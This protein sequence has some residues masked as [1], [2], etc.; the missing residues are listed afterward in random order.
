MFAY[1][2]QTNRI[3]GDPPD[4]TAY[5]RDVGTLDAYYEASMDLRAI[6]PPRSI[7]TTGSGRCGRA[8]TPIRP[9]S[10]PSTTRAGG[11]RRSTRWS[12]AAASCPAAWSRLGAG[13]RRAGPHRRGGRGFGRSSTMRYRPPGQDPPRHP[14]QERAHSERT[15]IGYDLEEDAEALPR[16][17]ERHRGGRRPPL[18]RAARQHHCLRV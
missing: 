15:P 8:A 10:S 5:W 2:F 3:P 11:A 16:H 17:R 1:D 4:G 14:R 13:P 12:R 7:S 18:P 6:D 9:R